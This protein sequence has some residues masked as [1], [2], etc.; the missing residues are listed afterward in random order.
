MDEP[1]RADAGDAAVGADLLARLRCPLDP[2]R[3]A[4]LDAEPGR[5][6][7][8]RCRLAFPVRDGF[9]TL[10]AEEAELPPGCG[11]TDRLPCQRDK[12]V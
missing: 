11:S 5:L 10:L 1:T 6:V 12:T 4:P 8:R 3:A 7:C 2:A 9:P